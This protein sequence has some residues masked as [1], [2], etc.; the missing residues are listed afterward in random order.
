M[1]TFAEFYKELCSDVRWYENCIMSNRGK[2]FKAAAEDVYAKLLADESIRDRPMSENRTHVYNR[3]R[4]LDFERVFPVLQQEEKK[5]EDKEWKPAS[6]EHVAKCVAE[7][8]E[9]LKNAPMMTS[10]P[11]LTNKQ[12][13]EQGDWLP[14]KGPAHKMTTAMEAYNKERKIAYYRYCFDPITRDKLPTWMEEEVYNAEFDRIMIK[15][16][17]HPNWEILQELD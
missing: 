12:K 4:K 8:N 17:K 3:L 14:P 5:V 7:F 11:R 2:N 6:D 1:N 10:F 13:A 15:K 16:K 9:M